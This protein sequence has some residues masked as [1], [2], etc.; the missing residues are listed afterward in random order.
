MHS[1]AN[2]R[3]FRFEEKPKGS[4]LLDELCIPPDLLNEL[5]R[6]A[7]CRT[8]PRLDGYLRLQP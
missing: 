5:G 2:R 7:R 8:L 1:D 4:K 3:I 6:A